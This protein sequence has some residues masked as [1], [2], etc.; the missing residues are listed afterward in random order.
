MSR[1]NLAIYLNDHLAGS[2]VALQLMDYLR[3]SNKETDLTRFLDEL[4][5]DV[6]AD[7]DVLQDLMER[8]E[9]AAST[10]RTAFAWLTEKFGEIKL[11]L[12]DPSGGPLHVLEALEAIAIGIDGKRAL[13]RALSAAHV[14]FL[15]E[16]EL[17]ALAQRAAEQRDRVESY[18]LEAAAIALTLDELQVAVEAPA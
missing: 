8:L 18:R 6:T 5:A 11:R 13:W 1:S 16:T 12:D 3:E 17:Q 4:H 15:S 9:I 10:P 7:R 2:V 14:G